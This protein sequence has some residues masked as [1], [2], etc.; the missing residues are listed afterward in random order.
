MKTK[1]KI[2][3]EEFKKLEKKFAKEKAQSTRHVVE[4]VA[5]ILLMLSVFVAI[6]KTS[7]FTANAVATMQQ[8]TSKINDLANQKAELITEMEQMTN[9][10][11]EFQATI[12]QL[13]ENDKQTS[14]AFMSVVS[15]LLGQ[16]DALRAR[17]SELE[18]TRHS[19]GGSGSTGT[20]GAEQ[21]KPP[22]DPYKPLDGGV[23]RI[24]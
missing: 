14:Q 21:A 1:Y 8:Q 7:Q 20:S 6:G 3:G 10:S 4:V 5:V 2:S 22:Y 13:K 9:Q 19:G 18:S 17:I 23:A 15:D 24:D 11:S 16:I 12:E